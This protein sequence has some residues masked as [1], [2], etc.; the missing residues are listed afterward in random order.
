[1]TIIDKNTRQS[2]NNE[3][4]HFR[5]ED[6]ETFLWGVYDITKKTCLDC[7]FIVEQYTNKRLVGMSREEF[8]EYVRDPIK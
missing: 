2:L 1:M 3:C 6:R 7:G 5:Y 4:V 8:E